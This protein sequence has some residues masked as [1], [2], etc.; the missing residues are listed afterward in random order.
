MNGNFTTVALIDFE[1][2]MVPPPPSTPLVC[3]VAVVML[4]VLSPADG[5]RDVRLIEQFHALVKSPKYQPTAAEMK[6]IKY[7]ANKLIGI[8]FPETTGISINAAIKT[9]APMLMAAD[10]VFANGP[11]LEQ[12]ILSRWGL[13]VHVHDIHDFL[14]VS[15]KS[16]KSRP[17]DCR[18]AAKLQMC[19]AHGFDEAHCALMDVHEIVHWIAVYGIRLPMACASYNYN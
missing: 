17:A 7:T 6:Q 14:T 11:A 16:R 9:I 18:E 19:T 12:R 5:P 4:A 10:Y 1:C 15:L 3:E 8:Q 13:N 2:F